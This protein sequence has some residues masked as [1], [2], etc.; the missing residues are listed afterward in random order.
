[1]VDERGRVLLRHPI[2][3][4]S[5]LKTKEVPFTNVRDASFS[6]KID[7]LDPVFN[8]TRVSESIVR[9][10]F[11]VKKLDSYEETDTH[12]KFS[13]ILNENGKEPNDIDMKNYEKGLIS[14]YKQTY[15]YDIVFTNTDFTYHHFLFWDFN[16][17]YDEDPFWQ[18]ALEGEANYGITRFP[19]IG[20]WI[21]DA[22]PVPEGYVQKHFGVEVPVDSRSGKL[23]YFKW[24][25]EPIGTLNMEY[26]HLIPTILKALDDRYEKSGFYQLMKKLNVKDKKIKETV[27]W[28]KKKLTESTQD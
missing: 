15:T 4:I 5:I 12:I 11:K 14:L 27:V 18:D 7:R 20:E 9:H 26:E 22:E 23:A 1:M 8:L 10:A 6:V 24:Q 2:K 17:Y 28:L 3:E 21:L 25:D 19:Y 13:V 16:P